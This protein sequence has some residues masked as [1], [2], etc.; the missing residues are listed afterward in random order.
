MKRS[1]LA[2]ILACIFLRMTA[3]QITFVPQ[4]TPQSQF[5]GFY[6]A[7]E[8]GFYAAAGLDVNIRHVGLS[9]T[10][11]PMA[12]LQSGEGQI[13]GMQMLQAIVAKSKGE[14]IVNVMQLTQSTGLCCAA[15]FPVTSIKDLD[16]KK[17][18][19]WSSGYSEICEIVAH[20]ENVNVNWIP[21]NNGINLYVYGAV[22]A[23]L[24]YS[25]SELNRL[26]LS[27]GNVPDDRVLHFS[28]LGY[29]WPEDGLYVTEEYYNNNKALI[30][31]F[32]S[33]S[34]EG[35]K[36][37]RENRDEAVKISLKYATEAHV[38]TN[39]TIEKMMLDEYLKIQ[40]NTSTGEDLF[41][42]VSEKTFSRMTGDLYELGF[43][44]RKVEYKEL[45]K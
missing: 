8:K 14:P 24:C 5:A 45:V 18:G 20:R 13:V 44:D 36:W 19:K 10:E 41:R 33:V 37:V 27:L 32:I 25:Y 17:I 22:D 12:L 43:I 2:A 35:W 40:T 26:I 23:V 42:P 38:Q 21:F 29:D 7:V 15:T 9:S 30:D 28:R 3:Q 4:W 6:A 11:T 31:K 39:L 34:V 16:G 1:L